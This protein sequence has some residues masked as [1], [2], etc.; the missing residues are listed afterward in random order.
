[1]YMNYSEIKLYYYMCAVT[2]ELHAYATKAI[3]KGEIWGTN[4]GNK[5]SAKTH[6]AGPILAIKLAK[7]SSP[8]N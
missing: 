1:M 6:L 3:L 2:E 4:F 8:G 5:S 7:I